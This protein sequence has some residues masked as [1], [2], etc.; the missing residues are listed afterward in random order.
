M[1]KMRVVPT[2][3]ALE[4]NIATFEA[5]QSSSAANSESFR[6]LIKRGTCFVPYDHNGKISFAP[7]RF[8]G[9]EENSIE[10]HRQ[11]SEK[12]GRITNEAITAI[13]GMRPQ[14]HPHFER[15][16]LQFCERTGVTPSRSGTFGAP[17][18]YWSTIEVRSLLE[19]SEVDNIN[20]D[21]NLTATEREQLSKA[22]VGQGLFRERLV[23]LWKRRCVV[24]DIKL[25]PVLKASHIKPWRD[26]TNAERLDKYNGL[27][28]SP[29]LDAL[30]DKGYISFRDNGE[31]LISPVLDATSVAS[32]LHG[33]DGKVNFVQEH[34][35]YLEHHREYVFKAR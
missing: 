14:P 20:E 18:K 21:L 19:S 17:R 30:F 16:Y 10:R 5:L 11:N 2:L 24:S 29:N 25:L 3:A 32:L 28:L 35:K 26:S 33:C 31:M 7:S 1:K 34:F 12:D 13:I 9:Y 4:K 6:N 22:R 23:A 8:I 15:L 27:L